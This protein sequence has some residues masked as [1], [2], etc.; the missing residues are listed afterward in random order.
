MTDILIEG[1]HVPVGVTKLGKLK[2]GIAWHQDGCAQVTITNKNVIPHKFE[3]VWVTEGDTQ[4][5][6]GVTVE[7]KALEQSN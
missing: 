6:A 3:R 2:I 4:E 1:K 7:H 5:V